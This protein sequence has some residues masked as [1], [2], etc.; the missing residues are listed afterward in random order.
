MAK[1]SFSAGEDNMGVSVP[2]GLLTVNHSSQ[3]QAAWQPLM[4]EGTL[5]AEVV[6]LLLPERRTSCHCLLTSEEV[7]WSQRPFPVFV[8]I[9][10]H[11]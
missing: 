10:V 7:L 6:P 4:P 9:T 3:C 2:G 11:L 1:A 8:F 5:Q